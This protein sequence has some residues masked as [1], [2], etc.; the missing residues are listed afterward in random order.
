MA[1]ENLTDREKKVLAIRQQLDAG[2]YDIDR[3]FSTAVDRLLEELV[4]GNKE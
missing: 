4:E 2:I 1:F 3:R